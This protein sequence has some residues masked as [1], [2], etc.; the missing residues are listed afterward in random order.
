MSVINLTAFC[1]VGCDKISCRTF[2]HGILRI[3]YDIRKLREL[4]LCIGLYN[5]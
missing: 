1:K 4:V 5:L 3:V 2:L